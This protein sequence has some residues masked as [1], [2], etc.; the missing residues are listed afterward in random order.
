MGRDEV[1][2][3]SLFA[4]SETVTLS[5]DLINLRLRYVYTLTKPPPQPILHDVQYS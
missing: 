3:D 5:V 4:F 1:R 2:D